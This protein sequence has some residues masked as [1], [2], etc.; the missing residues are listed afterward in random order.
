[1]ND[2]LE[3]HI[4][5]LIRFIMAFRNPRILLDPKLWPP[6]AI[7][8]PK[9]E[10]AI[11]V[12][13]VLATTNYKK[14]H[15][16]ERLDFMPFPSREVAAE[17]NAMLVDYL[18]EFIRYGK[19]ILSS[20]KVYAEDGRIVLEEHKTGNKY[21]A[22]KFADV[23]EEERNEPITGLMSQ[24]L[25]KDYARKDMPEPAGYDQSIDDK[26]D[27]LQRY[28]YIHVIRVNLRTVLAVSELFDKQKA[29]NMMDEIKTEYLRE[30]REK[31]KER[32]DAK[33]KY[34]FDKKHLN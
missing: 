31:R 7:L 2:K 21:I 10:E 9:I 4:T 16:Q 20:H 32:R 12:R 23:P 27:M 28:S 34:Y 30:Q 13:N 24:A 33:R 26:L 5:S 17:F 25:V 15:M 14:Y 1:M 22:L 19:Q 29:A 3:Q 8:G 6:D 11:M 18:T